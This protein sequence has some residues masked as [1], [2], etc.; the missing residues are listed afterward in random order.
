M[1][2]LSYENEFRM[3]FHFHANQSHF[4][5]NSFALRLAL[6]QRHKGTR[7]WP[8]G[9]SLIWITIFRVEKG[10]TGDL[11][12]GDQIFIS[13][14]WHLCNS[15]DFEQNSDRYLWTFWNHNAKR[16][17]TLA[18]R[19]VIWE[20]CYS[21][22]IPYSSFSCF[23]ADIQLNTWDRLLEWNKE[24]SDNSIRWWQ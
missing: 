20:S 17:Q 21:R 7:K 4:H 8:I 5:N 18:R 6:K 3:Q 15:S 11:W 9:R 2:N 22:P 24:I 19:S 1:W 23:C 16:F 14:S 10:K 12:S 13:S